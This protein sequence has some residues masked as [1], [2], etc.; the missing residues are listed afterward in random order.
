MSKETYTYTDTDAHTLILTLF[1]FFSL[2]RPFLGWVKESSQYGKCLK[3]FPKS[4]FNLV[5]LNTKKV[6]KQ[7]CNSKEKLEEAFSHLKC[8]QKNTKEA[9]SMAMTLVNSLLVQIT[10]FENVD[11]MIPGLCCGTTEIFQALPSVIDNV[12]LPLTGPSTGAYITNLMSSLLQELIDIMCGKYSTRDACIKNNPYAY[13][14]VIDA[15]INATEYN[16]T[17]AIPIVNILYKLD[18]VVTV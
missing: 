18:G 17:I 11:D 10:E 5:L 13:Q 12:C 14:K 2:I 16:H 9:I 4:L 6:H 15:M 8:I 1:V 7:I 3:P